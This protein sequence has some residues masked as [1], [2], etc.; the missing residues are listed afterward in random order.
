MFEEIRRPFSARTVKRNLGEAGLKGCK[1]QKKAMAPREMQ[2]ARLKWVIKHK[3][4][5]E[6][7]W[8]NVMWSDEPNIEEG[9]LLLSLTFKSYL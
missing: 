7:D 3:H 9:L 5:M 1:A 4:L 8:A 6:E 2:K